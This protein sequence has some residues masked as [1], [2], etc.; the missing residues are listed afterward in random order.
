MAEKYIK[1]KL[2]KSAFGRKPNQGKT[3][4][5]IAEKKQFTEC[6]RLLTE[7]EKIKQH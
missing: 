5:E 6:V 2:V 4:K 7:V 1:I 3:L